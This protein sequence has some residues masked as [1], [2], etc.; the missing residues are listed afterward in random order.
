M[1]YMTRS[2]PESWVGGDGEDL[3][4]EEKVHNSHLGNRL[5]GNREV[6]LSDSVE[7]Y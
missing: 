4:T 5:I 3:R 7:C 2:S 6:S 1:K